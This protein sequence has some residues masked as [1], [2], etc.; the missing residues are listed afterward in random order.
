MYDEKKESRWD[1]L[2]KEPEVDKKLKEKVDLFIS[3][4]TQ[5]DLDEDIRGICGEIFILC[6]SNPDAGLE[7]IKK[8]ISEKQVLESYVFLKFCKARAYQIKGV[9]PLKDRPFVKV[10]VAGSEELRLYLNDENLNYLELVVLSIFI[11][12][13]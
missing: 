5:E 7:W 10:G 3:G 12:V 1:Y 13:L 11:F 4:E 9:Q 2:G 8:I 6:E